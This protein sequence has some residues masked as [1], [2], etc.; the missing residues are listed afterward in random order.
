MNAKKR[1]LPMVFVIAIAAAGGYLWKTYGES[2][3]PLTFYGNVD[4]REVELA[5]RQPGRLMTV[6]VEE[7]DQVASG[8]VLALLD[9]TPYRDALAQTEAEVMK[10]QAE[11]DK[12]EAGNRAQ[13]IKAAEAAVREARAVLQQRESDLK[14][15]TQLVEQGDSSHK[16]LEV[17]RMDRDVA[18]ASLAS[19]LEALSL[20]RE[21]ARVED[22]AA[23]RAQL[24][25]AKANLAQARTALDDTVLLAPSNAVVMSRVRE[26]GS[27]VTSQD[28]VY[29]LSLRNPVY[30]RAYVDEPSLGKI[31]QG[32]RV[33]IHTDSS[34]KIYQGQIG[35]IS[36]RAEFTPKSVETVDLRTDLV[37][38]LRIT[39]LNDDEA[40][41]QGMP[42]TIQLVEDNT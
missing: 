1:I 28:A 5:F 25:A 41:K 27:M 20:Q 18:A 9:D 7:G 2:D 35:F 38:R 22:I 29:T 11:L 34:S 4:I 6:K 3:A 13:E 24:E 19:A 33:T 23:A 17:V 16:N 14:R 8:D 21:G 30:V 26:P 37:Y 12:Q 39:V 40:L 36:P 10:A 15:Q 31:A 32:G 42:V